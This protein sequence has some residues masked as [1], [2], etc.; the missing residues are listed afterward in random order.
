MGAP[1]LYV[2]VRTRR[3]DDLRLTIPLHPRTAYATVSLVT[4]V[5]VFPLA[6]LKHSKHFTFRS[7][8][9]V[10]TRSFITNAVKEASVHRVVVVR[11][12]SMILLFLH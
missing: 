7:Q 5:R 10:S 9:I 8:V 3:F 4:E 12:L 2:M 11:S 1:V 6:L